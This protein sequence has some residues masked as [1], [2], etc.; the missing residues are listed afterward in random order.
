MEKPQVQHDP[1]FFNHNFETVPSLIP[2]PPYE[3]IHPYA[4]PVVSY[5]PP[6][7]FASCN[8]PPAPV[9]PAPGQG[10]NNNDCVNLLSDVTAF[11]IASLFLGG[12]FWGLT[13]LTR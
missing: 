13:W 10:D 2:P 11:L 3:W 9:L 4:N 8:P 12:F 1:T 6:V 7:Q 5:D